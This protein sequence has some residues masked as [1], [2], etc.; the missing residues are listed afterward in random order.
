MTPAKIS[1]LLFYIRIFSFRNF[2]ALA[3]V[4]AGIVISHGIG[5]FFAAIFQCS[6][7]AYTWN[8]T[9]VGGSCFDQEAFYRYVS[10]PNI[11]TDVLIL[12]MPL[13]YVWKLHTQ[14][15]QKVALT[16]VFLLGSLW[17][18]PL[19]DKLRTFFILTSLVEELS[20]VFFAWQLSSKTA[21]WLT[22]P[23]CQAK[24]R[25]NNRT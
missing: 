6:P 19:G 4:V 23:V 15:G 25:Y 21:P 10:P 12:V 2:R 5:V 24:F 7:I 13:P 17:V 11:V 3:Y 18:S 16:G 1:I 14:V 20:P 9:I 8:K 22:Q